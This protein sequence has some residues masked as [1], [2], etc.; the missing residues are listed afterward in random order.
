MTC[1]YCSKSVYVKKRN[2]C[3]AHYSML[4]R[5]GDPLAS[6]RNYG[7]GISSNTAYRNYWYMMGRCYNENDISY[8]NYGGRGIKVCNR[9]F[10]KE[11]FV[12]FLS[13]IG[14]KPSSKHSLDRIDSEKDYEPTNC[15]WATRHQQNSNKRNSLKHVGVFPKKNGSWFAYLTIN[16]TRKGKTFKTTNEAIKYR[17]ELEKALQTY[18]ACGKI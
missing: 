17:K 12:N 13:D 15:R 16:G 7:I 11:G 4:S 5:R 6:T 1:T 18:N 9:W 8:P 3:Q 2:L 14:E 10:G